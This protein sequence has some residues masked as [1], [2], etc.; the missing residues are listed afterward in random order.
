MSI[1]AITGLETACM[2]SRMIFGDAL[3]ATPPWAR[4]CAGTRSRAITAVAPAVS[5][6]LAWSALVTSIITPPLSI[7][8]RPVL[9][10]IPVLP[11]FSDMGK[12]LNARGGRVTTF[13]ST[14]RLRAKNQSQNHKILKRRGSRG[15]RG[16]LGIITLAKAFSYACEITAEFDDNTPRKPL[17]PLLP[18][19]F[20]VLWFCSSAVLGRLRKLFEHALR[21]EDATPGRAAA[22]QC[23]LGLVN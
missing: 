3:R 19:R 11:F 1:L 15:S 10:L 18:L 4:I 8:A 6:I 12:L 13:Y 17:L 21:V 5:A 23:P 20:K 7:S 16:F 9:S 22:T 14:A 2:I